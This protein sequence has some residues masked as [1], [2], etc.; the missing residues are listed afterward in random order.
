MLLA[1]DNGQATALCLL[2]LTAAFDTVNH[3]LLLLHLEQQFGNHG[4]ALKL[5]RSYLASRSFHVI[6]GNSTSTIIHTVCPV[7]LSSQLFISYKA[8]LAL[9]AKKHNVNIHLFADNT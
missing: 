5:F 6:Y 8:D 9:M 4:V 7:V 2:D 3:D 1:A